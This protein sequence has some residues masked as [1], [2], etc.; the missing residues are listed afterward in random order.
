MTPPRD[1]TAMALA[2][3]LKKI[4]PDEPD[5][6]ASDV[7]YGSAKKQGELKKY[8]KTKDFRH[9]TKSD[10]DDQNPAPT[11]YVQQITYIHA[12]MHANME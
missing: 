2:P 10:S 4:G 6:I 8:I 1:E 12:C 3:T 11:A 9:P 5:S 7:Q